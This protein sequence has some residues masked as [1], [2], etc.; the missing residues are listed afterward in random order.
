MYQ[1]QPSGA[2]ES[3]ALAM[4]YLVG[5][6]PR[7]MKQPIV[8]GDHRPRP[9]LPLNVGAVRT[10]VPRLTVVAKVRLE[11]GADARVQVPILDRSDNLHATVEVSRHPV[12]RAKVQ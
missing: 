4:Q 6:P 3:L 7:I 10:Q 5:H 1:P 11:Q 2:A 8:R 12:G 9:W